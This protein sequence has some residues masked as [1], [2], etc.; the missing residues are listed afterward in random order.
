MTRVE[1]SAEAGKIRRSAG[2]SIMLRSQCNSATTPP[3]GGAP[4]TLFLNKP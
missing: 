1:K 2:L 3:D 4:Q